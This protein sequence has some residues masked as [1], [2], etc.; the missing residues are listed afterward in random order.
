MTEFILK[1]DRSERIVAVPNHPSIEPT[2]IDS[3]TYYVYSRVDHR[4]G[5]KNSFL[6]NSDG[7]Y[8]QYSEHVF[9]GVPCEVRSEWS[10]SFYVEKT[11]CTE[12]YL[13]AMSGIVFE[14]D[15]SNPEELYYYKVDDTYPNLYDE[16]HLYSH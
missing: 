9:S 15:M 16:I 11:R 12:L 3:L 10:N 13:R 14:I 5:T 8:N 6:V 1:Y 2:V 4:A 7:S